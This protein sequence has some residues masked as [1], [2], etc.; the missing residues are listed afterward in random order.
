[1]IKCSVRP[2][3]CSELVELLVEGQSPV[4]SLQPSAIAIYVINYVINYVIFKFRSSLFFF[5]G[6]IS[7]TSNPSFGR[8]LFNG[9]AVCQ[10][11]LLRL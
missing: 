2:G 3:R 9:P 8:Y 11:N 10:N 6:F 7:P 5:T 1:M 4:A